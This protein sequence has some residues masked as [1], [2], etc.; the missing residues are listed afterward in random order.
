MPWRQFRNCLSIEEMNRGVR[1]IEYGVLQRR[2]A[3]IL[4]VSQSVISR[5]WNH[6]LTHITEILHTYMAETR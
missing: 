6:H 5:M 2:V 1:L 4:D 3:G